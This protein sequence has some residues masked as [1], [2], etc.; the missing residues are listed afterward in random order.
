MLGIKANGEA[1]SYTRCDMNS[2]NNM[3]VFA[4]WEEKGPTDSDQNWGLFSQGSACMCLVSKSK[5]QPSHCLILLKYLMFLEV[6]FGGCG[7]F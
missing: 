4:N 7:S 3:A 1:I 2:A 5:V 6:H